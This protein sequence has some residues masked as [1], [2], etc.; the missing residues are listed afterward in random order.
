MNDALFSIQETVKTEDV[1][2]V[3]LAVRLGLNRSDFKRC[4][5]SHA[6][7]ERIAVD[8]RESMS[9]KLTGTP[10][11]LVGERLFMGRIPEPELEQLL[12]ATP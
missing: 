5:E 10:S 9:R 11:F 8:V 12:V 6:T 4:L 7:A 2:P 1:D 3:E